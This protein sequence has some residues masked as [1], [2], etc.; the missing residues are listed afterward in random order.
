[1]DSK[2]YDSLKK[3][4]SLPEFDELDAEFE[5]SAIELESWMLKNICKKIGERLEITIDV[6]EK[7]FQPDT[8]SYSDVYECKFFTHTE[9]DAL[10]LL[11]KQLMYLYRSLIEIEAVNDEKVYANFIKDF[12]SEWREIKKSLLPF[13]V[14]LK[15]TWKESTHKKERLEYLG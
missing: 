4:Y 12:V 1:M 5:I 8:N 6:V 13:L 3:K 14:K 2:S 7:I 9:K 11:F 15:T 10:M